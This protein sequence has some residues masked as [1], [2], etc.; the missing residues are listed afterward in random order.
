MDFVGDENLEIIFIIQI[1][2]LCIFLKIIWTFYD[3]GHKLMN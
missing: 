2:L 3:Y 1:P